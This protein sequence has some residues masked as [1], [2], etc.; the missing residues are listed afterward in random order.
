MEALVI[1]REEEAKIAE[2]KEE[3]ALAGRQVSYR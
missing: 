2:H 1:Y 3:C